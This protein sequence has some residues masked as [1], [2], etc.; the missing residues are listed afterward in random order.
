MRTVLLVAL[1]LFFR[2]P[3][4]SSTPPTVAAVLFLGNRSFSTAELLEHMTTREGSKFSRMQWIDDLN[5]IRDFYVRNGYCFVEVAGDSLLQEKD[6]AHI[7]ITMNIHEGERLQIG[8][9]VLQGN[10]LFPDADILG[11]FESQAGGMLS[12]ETLER[13]IA[14]LLNRYEQNGYPFAQVSVD[15]L[16]PYADS[17]GGERLRVHLAVTEG[18]RTTIEEIRVTGNKETHAD[19]VVRETRI[20]LHESYNPDKIA[21]ITARL[22]RLNIFSRVDPP[23]LYVNDRGGGLLIHVEEGN[24]NFF[25]GIIGYA[26]AQQTGGSGIV[27][28]FVTVTMRNLF[29]TAR[30]LD[31]RW[32]RDES[33]AQE[34]GLQY[35]EPW[36]FGLPVNLAGGFSQRQ[37]D[38]S[39]VQR[40]VDGRADLL[41]NESLTL[42]AL[43][44]LESVIPSSTL[45]V[46]VVQS[47]HTATGGL[48]LKY[49]TRDDVLSP[50]SGVDYVSSYHFGSK[51]TNG[52]V[53]SNDFTVQKLSI[54]VQFFA[55]MATHQ[56]LALGVHGRE[57]SG[58]GIELSDLFRLGGTNTLRGYR[59]NQF[60]GS[61]IA[62]TNAEYR[63]L[64]ARRSYV[65]GFFDTGYYFVPAD[66]TNGISSS[67]EMKYGYGIGIRM[68]TSLG[69]IGVS[70]AFGQGDSFSDGKIHV[71]LANTF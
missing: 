34:L 71:G 24:P 27:T 46:A 70:F 42:S 67:Q 14:A 58:G 32:Q 23:E 39:Y 16:L 9:V 26:P 10:H 69:N 60:L 56:V 13:D 8:A 53:Q 45:S 36:I 22:N 2:S 35:V 12:S 6:S 43:A 44:S 63:F 41:V 50:T 62:W 40:S 29:G 17:A 66:E 55:E 21:K 49:D 54:D 37:Q 47:S 4:I 5:A 11:H 51:T 19:V 57:R 18:K 38:S 65:F 59:E 64:L 20:S 52:P 25:D 68:E 3:L 28:G 7:R 15:T 61:R 48:E 33:D 31:V 30:K 1:V